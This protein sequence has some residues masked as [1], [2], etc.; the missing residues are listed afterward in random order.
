MSHSRSAKQTRVNQAA[1]NIER[2]KS[3]HFRGRAKVPLEFLHFS[4]HSPR[5][6]DRG[7]VERLRDVFREQGVKRL[8]SGNHIPA[9]VGKDD[10]ERAVQLSGLSLLDILNGSQ[11][12]PPL[13]RFPD[14]FRLECLHGKHRVEAAKL[15]AWWTVTLYSAGTPSATYLSEQAKTSLIEDYSSSQKFSDGLVFRKLVEY[16]TSDPYSRQHWWS[17]LTDCKKDILSRIF[18]HKEYNAALREMIRIPALLEDINITVWHKIIA[19]RSDEEFLHYINRIMATFDHICGRQARLWIALDSETVAQLQSRCPGASLKD[20]RYLQSQLRER[21]IFRAVDDA[22]REEI[23]TRLSAVKYLIPTLASLQQDFKYIR[24]PAK[25][26]YD[27]LKCPKSGRRGR[28]ILRGMAESTFLMPRLDG[29]ITIQVTDGS[30][31]EIAGHVDDQFEVAFQQ[32]YLFAMRESW[33]LVNDCPLKEQA[34]KTPTARSADPIVWYGFAKF[35]C[36]QGF[37]LPEIQ[38]LIKT[39]PFEEKA[40]QAL[41]KGQ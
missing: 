28:Q 17:W 9:V 2:Q 1:E 30:T 13:L 38:R 24:G 23:W 40:R 33:D 34:R 29:K 8:T 26:V 39:N 10:L 12:K 14:G 35:A 20:S 16:E 18:A 5:Q 19:T 27:L 32:L 3:S 11:D 31:Q 15:S 36:S 6:L 41:P 25:A 4:E 21:R 37:D 22:T 7:N